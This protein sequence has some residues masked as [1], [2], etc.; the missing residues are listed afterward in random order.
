MAKRRIFT[1]INRTKYNG[2]YPIVLKSSWEELFASMYCDMN[3]SCLEWAYEPWKIPYRDP[4]ADPIRYPDGKQTIYIPDFL[5]S[6]LTPEGRIRTSLIEIKPLHEAL[7]EHTRDL[8]DMREH[9]RN[10]AKWQAAIAWCQR[11]G[12]V[13]FVVL[14]E[15][16]LPIETK[17]QK[18][19]RRRYTKRRVKKS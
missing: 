10:L 7:Q 5:M 2:A 17:I 9:A 3:P 1:P 6:F 8:K 18:P 14:T 16:E 11:R 13:E 12:D 4:T 19:K 15:A